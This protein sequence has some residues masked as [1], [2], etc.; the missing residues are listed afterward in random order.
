MRP[1]FVLLTLLTA[2]TAL[3]KP[4]KLSRHPRS[5]QLAEIAFSERSAKVSVDDNQA[6]GELAGWAIENPS[7]LIVLDGH[8]APGE[9]DAVML[10]MHRAEA[11]RDEL[12]GLGVDPNSVVVAA[13]GGAGAL[14][15]TDRRVVA[16]GTL[17]DV[18]AVMTRLEKSGAV[19]VEH[20]VTARPQVAR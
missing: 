1:S 14:S 7:G 12:V 20:G 4:A 6:I 15:Q 8:A 19:A 13:F 11:V 17:N 5:G 10:S 9:P 2:G 3:A 16:W 18:D